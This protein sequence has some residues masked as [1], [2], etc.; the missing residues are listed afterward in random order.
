MS[1][2]MEVFFKVVGELSEMD[3]NKTTEVW[4]ALQL[5]G[6]L[7][8]LK[9]DFQCRPNGDEMVYTKGDDI[10]NRIFCWMCQCTYPTIE[11]LVNHRQI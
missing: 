2:A 11:S 1:D 10:G 9:E 6:I 8:G 4:N 7:I 3:A 5:N